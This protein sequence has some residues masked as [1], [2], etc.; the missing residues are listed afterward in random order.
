M[1]KRKTKKAFF[2]ILH[3]KIDIPHVD[4]QSNINNID[5][6]VQFK[7]LNKYITFR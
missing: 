3:F 1:E 6:I 2:H 7:V 4:S 5:F